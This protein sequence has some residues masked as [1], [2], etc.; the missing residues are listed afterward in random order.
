ME[1]CIANVSR[2]EKDFSAGP[3]TGEREAA[4]FIGPNGGRPG[5]EA[6]GRNFPEANPVD[7]AGCVWAA[8]HCDANFESDDWLGAHVDEPAADELLSP[9][10][11]LGG[12]L[13]GVGVKGEPVQAVALR[14]RQGIDFEETGG[15]GA[16]SVKLEAAVVAGRAATEDDEFVDVHAGRNP[17]RRGGGRARQP[18]PLT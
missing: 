7:W 3:D 10:P 15:P 11:D 16:R 5:L 12:G 17:G 18:A 6:C 4:V 13:L 8:N 9:E 2:I 14:C 1:A